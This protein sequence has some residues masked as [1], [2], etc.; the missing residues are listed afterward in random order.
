MEAAE[1][2]GL[3]RRASVT[4]QEAV[5]LL[6]LSGSYIGFL[7]DHYADSFI[8]DGAM[9]RIAWPEFTYEVQF[10]AIARRSPPPTRIAPAFWQALLDSHAAT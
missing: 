10:V 1:R 9:R 4:D 3:R 6:I 2:F 8:A 7:P 5:A